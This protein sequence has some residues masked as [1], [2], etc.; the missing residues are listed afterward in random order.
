MTDTPIEYNS[1]NGIFMNSGFI[2]G[3]DLL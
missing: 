3:T 2:Q 1:L